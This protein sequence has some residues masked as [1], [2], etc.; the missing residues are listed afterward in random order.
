MSLRTVID[1]A[2][3]FENFRNIDLFHQGLYHLKARVKHESGGDEW[4]A[5]T[6]YGH[7]AAPLL[8]SQVDHRPKGSRVDHHSLIGAQLLED[9]EAFVTRSFLIRYCEEEVEIHDVGHFRLEVDTRPAKPNGLVLLLQ[10]E[11]MFADLAQHGGADAFGENTDLTSLEFKRVSTQTFRVLGA[12]QGLH[13]FSPVVFDEFHFCLANMVVQTA[14][15]D[16]RFR[17]LPSLMSSTGAAPAQGVQAS[18]GA[19]E[20]GSTNCAPSVSPL[21]CESLMLH[22]DEEGVPM[23]LMECIFGCGVDKEAPDSGAW[24]T[25]PGGL[26][27]AAESFCQ[28]YLDLLSKSYQKL[29]AWFK[30]ICEK[31][32]TPGQRDSL[33][34]ALDMHA[35]SNPFDTFLSLL[36]D[37][38]PAYPGMQLDPELNDLAVAKEGAAL[39]NGHGRGQ[40][41]R[42]FFTHK[43]GGKVTAQALTSLIAYNLNAVSMQL[44]TLW[45]NIIDVS[46]IAGRELVALLRKSWEQQTSEQWRKSVV[47]QVVKQDLG[48]ITD[49]TDI[50]VLHSGI[51]RASSRAIGME[52]VVEDEKGNGTTESIPTVLE[53]RYALRSAAGQKN[54]MAVKPFDATLPAAPKPYRGLHLF[55]LIHGFQ[56]NSFDMRLMKNNLA[57]MYPDA[58]FLMSNVNEDNT[59]GDMS[60]MGIRLAQ[61]VVNFIS[62]WCPG[63]ALGRLSFVAYSIGGLILRAALPLLKEFKDK[64][65][66]FLSF[67]TPHLGYMDQQSPLFNA[68]V[69][70]LKKWR[71]IRCL[72]QLTMTD[73]TDP[74][75]SFLYRLSSSSGIEHFKWVVVVSSKQDNYAPFK[76]SRVE[77][78]PSW[79]KAHTKEAYSSMVRN[80][81]EGIQYDRVLRLNVH[82]DLP[83]RN[84]DK[85]IGRA[86]HIKFIENQALMRM[87]IH[88]YSFLFR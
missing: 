61:E 44:Y 25:S 21:R 76:S 62:D 70:S 43:L 56:G 73:T 77:I 87:I 27:L 36:G 82:F 19:S 81:W 38:S 26:L 50:S 53:Q 30:E 39:V 68:V 10:V 51:K 35:A 20:A 46:S 6:P 13:E 45:H 5:A 29:T 15:L 22:P 58:I 42:V 64:M 2:V 47:R 9:Q 71:K 12:T 18:S 11:L 52:V 66:T 7:S 79:D 3:L 78:C 63:S 32:L 54:G 67:S 57:M 34:E 59:E 48:A 60:E 69:W 31:C 16:V 4:T 65:Y 33:A 72:D 55:V 75:E 37:S 88:N 17:L 23:S 8:S 28:L 85:A 24:R 1:V 80:F 40:Q 74:K 41:L 14:V 49:D 83:E 86:A 84:L